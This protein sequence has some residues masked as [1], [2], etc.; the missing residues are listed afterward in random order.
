MELPGK[1]R[2]EQEKR[3]FREVETPMEHQPNIDVE[4][5]GYPVPTFQIAG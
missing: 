5:F 2:V 4:D 1:Y 3:M